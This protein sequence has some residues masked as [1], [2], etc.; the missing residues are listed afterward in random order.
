MFR[1][2]FGKRELPSR[3]NEIDIILI[4]GGAAA[5]ADAWALGEALLM[6]I[7]E[8]QQRALFQLNELPPD[9]IAVCRAYEFGNALGDWTVGGWF[10]SSS[11]AR[12]VAETIR[13]L[14]L[15]GANDVAD[16]LHEAANVWTSGGPEDARAAAM[17]RFNTSREQEKPLIGQCSEWVRAW[18][19]TMILGDGK[20]DIT[21]K[22]VMKQLYRCNL[23]YV[24]R[25]TAENQ[26]RMRLGLKPA[27][28]A[29]GKPCT[30]EEL[31][32][33]IERQHG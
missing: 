4:P 30:L 19:R 12:P 16:L 7:T 2:Q 21:Y 17:E 10:S 6:F 27:A 13:G 23:E 32:A 20:L 18:P 33:E 14:R 8:A 22:E 3:T 1:R 11:G 28:Q 15:I 26:R 24:R 25:R 29:Q 5:S 9:A 31:I